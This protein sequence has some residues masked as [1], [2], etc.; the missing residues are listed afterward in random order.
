VRNAK[1]ESVK[2]LSGHSN[3]QS[4]GH[5]NGSSETPH[6][7]S[8]DEGAT[9]NAANQLELQK[10]ADSGSS[11]RG[12]EGRGGQGKL[13]RSEVEK[14]LS[15]DLALEREAAKGLHK[16]LDQAQLRCKQTI[17][18]LS[19]FRKTASNRIK[20]VRTDCSM[21]IATL[22]H[23]PPQEVVHLPDVSVYRYHDVC[24]LSASCSCCSSRNEQT[25]PC[26]ITRWFH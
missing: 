17:E 20:V 26:R 4:N 9:K 8:D 12:G 6:D 13:G 25:A 22:Q 14:I 3:G 11:T 19:L 23:S 7:T 10:M 1:R 5:S 21:S 15:G 18:E 24:Y 2:E 16:E